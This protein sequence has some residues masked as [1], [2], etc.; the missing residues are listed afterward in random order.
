M[1]E[2]LVWVMNKLETITWGHICGR[3][4]LAAMKHAWR[5]NTRD[6]RVTFREIMAQGCDW[7]PV[8]EKWE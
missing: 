2:C 1:L 8:R 5:R 6:R 7:R 3:G 4:L